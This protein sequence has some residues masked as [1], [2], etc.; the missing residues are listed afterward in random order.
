MGGGTLTINGKRVAINGEANILELARRH[1]IE[2]PSFCYHSELSVYGA[3]RLCLVDIEGMGIQAACSTA[4]RDG[5]VI[6][7]HTSEIQKMRKM[8]LELLFASHYG[9]CPTCSKNGSCKLQSLAYQLG[10]TK[11][12]FEDTAKE[13]EIDDW[14]PSIIRDPSKCILCGDCVRMCRE[15]QGIG[16]LDFAYRGSRAIVQ[17]AFGRK[18][19][20][21]ECVNC[22]QCVAV[23]PTGALAARS[24]IDRVWKAIYDPTKTVITQIAPAVR[25]SLGEE[26]GLAPGEGVTGKIAAALRLVGFDKVFDTVFTA[27]LT[28][29]EETVEF[30][31]RL[32]NEERLPLFTSCCPAWVKYCE[33]FHPELLANLSTC[34]SPQQMFG[35][36]A[37]RFYAQSIG[38]SPGDLFVVSIMPCTAKKFEAKRP[39][40]VH[41]GV[42]DVDAVLTSVEAARLIKEVGVDF[43]QLEP[44]A[45]DS[46]FGL[47]SGAGTIFGVTGGV[48]EAVVRTAYA[49]TE[50]GDLGRL[51]YDDVRG[52]EGIKKAEIEVGGRPI[53]LRVVHGLANAE[54]LIRMYQSGE[55]E[56]EI[57][58]I[59]AC[60]VGCVGGGGQP[61]PNDLPSRK[62]R[63]KGL[64][65]LDKGMQLKNPL[66]NPFIDK[67]YALWLTKPGS[68]IAHHTLHTHYAPRRR[69][70]GETIHGIVEATEPNAVDVVVCVGTGCFLK[71]SYDVLHRIIALT[72]R[73]G[74]AKR[75]N[76]AAT[77]CLENCTDGV[78]MKVNGELLRGVNRNNVEEIFQQKILA[79]LR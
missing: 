8:A 62:Q 18:L 2:I 15:V 36:L 73:N 76:V 50:K 6:R 64:Y 32:E 63:G 39:E 26:F 34:R 48:A 20:E 60:P 51:D 37:K 69:I 16:V 31:G 75:I 23:C 28:A 38:V 65:L 25:V 22:G 17:P 12:R 71:G 68:E 43:G 77:F 67:V 24:E 13:K 56:F 27:D 19:S 49:L 54:R 1:G 7:T 3:C 45:L 57:A 70:A 78:S 72:E 52:I 9:D 41:N 47:V 46:P 79:A 40:F 59:M 14:G 58:E 55:D 66:E 42:A 5:M 21:V 44:E 30:V 29:L 11:V 53:R 61:L 10:V 74:L 33:Q 35:S 4:P